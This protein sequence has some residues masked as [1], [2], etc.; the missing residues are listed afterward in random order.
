MT[1]RQYHWSPLP[2]SKLQSLHHAL[3]DSG[4]S[5]GVSY[6]ESRILFCDV[7]EDGNPKV[8]YGKLNIVKIGEIEDNTAQPPNSISDLLMSAEFKVKRFVLIRSS[9]Y[10][11]RLLS[12]GFE[13]EK[14]NTVSLK[15]DRVRGMMIWLVFLHDADLDQT[16]R[17]SH[18]DETVVVL[19][20]LKCV[21]E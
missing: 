19:K 4:C 9:S 3:I 10:F 7:H 13:E 12:G 11:R 20:P 18:Q 5:L 15:D 14:E 21:Q 6:E 8:P 1:H 2:V 17:F 16:Y